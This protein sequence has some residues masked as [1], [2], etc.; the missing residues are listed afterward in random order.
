MY[1]GHFMANTWSVMATVLNQVTTCSAV[2]TCINN[3]GP[4]FG[5]VGTD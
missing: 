5:D 3:P 1:V 4:G 2:A